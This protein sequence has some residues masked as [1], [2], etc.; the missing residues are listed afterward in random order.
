MKIMGKATARPS[1][2]FTLIELLVVIGII[3][4]LLAITGP[5]AKPWLDK[6]RAESQIRTMHADLLQARTLAMQ[7][8]KEYFVKINSGNYQIIEDTNENGAIDASP[9]DT[10]G[11]LKPLTYAVSATGSV[12]VPLTLTIDTRGI[13]SAAGLVESAWLRFDTRS[14]QPEFDCLQL[15]PTRISV[16]RMDETSCVPR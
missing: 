1:R 14:T 11:E 7:K 16:G 12:A 10:Y 4:I 5:L 15:Y 8:N 9:T 13:I 3:A 6:Y 2:G